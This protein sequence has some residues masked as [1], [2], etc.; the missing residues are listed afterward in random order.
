MKK[1]SLLKKIGAILLL[2][3][4]FVVGGVKSEAARK[5]LLQYPGINI[6]DANYDTDNIIPADY[7]TLIRPNY[8]M[9]YTVFGDDGKW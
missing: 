6:V 8:R 3:F 5:P 9:S 1:Q 7:A 2:G 4:L